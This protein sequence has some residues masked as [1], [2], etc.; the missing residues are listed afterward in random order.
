[1]GPEGLLT[2]YEKLRTSY[3][4]GAISEAD[5]SSGCQSLM[6]EDDAGDWW[7]IDVT[8]QA[9][10]YDQAR[11]IWV[12]SAL[13]KRGKAASGQSDK[14]HRKHSKRRSRGTA[15]EAAARTPAPAPAKGTAMVSLVIVFGVSFVMSWV[16]WG[17]L[18]LVP[19]TINGIIPT[20]SCSNFNPGSAGMYV[21]SALVGLRVVFGSLVL[22]VALIMARKPIA[23][24]ISQINQAIPAN[25][26]SVMPAILAALFFAI[27]WAGSHANTGDLTGILPHRAFPALVGVFVHLTLTYG[28]GFMARHEGFFNARDRLPKF[29]RWF[30][31]FLIPT[32]VSLIITYQDRVTSVAFKQQIVVIIGM[33]AAFIIMTPRS[34]NLSD[35]RRGLE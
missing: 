33:L 31:V 2:E 13:P 23:A 15:S 4:A 8:G 21:C 12:E 18:S 19:L 16:G 1:M 34:G 10:M 30:L 20:G 11:A 35:L 25:Y 29:S 22:A 27:V 28:P 7:T 26:R 17:I 9:L 3:D 6:A 32:G 14:T 5:F 24:I